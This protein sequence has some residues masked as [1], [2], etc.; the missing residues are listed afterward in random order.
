MAEVYEVGCA[1]PIDERHS[2]DGTVK[3]LFPAAQGK[4]VEAVYIPDGDR[5]APRS[6]S[7]LRWVAR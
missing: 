7:L 5:T 1:A 4:Y 2:V 6:V 3:Y